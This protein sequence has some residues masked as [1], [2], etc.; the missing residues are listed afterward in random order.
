MHGR[1]TKEAIAFRQLVTALL[2]ESSET[3][4]KV[5][6]DMPVTFYTSDGEA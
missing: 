5:K 1:Y 6:S 4:E 2:R 3:V